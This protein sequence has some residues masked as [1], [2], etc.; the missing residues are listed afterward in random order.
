MNHPGYISIYIEVR[1]G[2]KIERLSLEAKTEAET[3]EQ[4]DETMSETIEK[5][6][7]P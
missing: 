2:R 7:K 4:E 5:K 1:R 3:V 6:L